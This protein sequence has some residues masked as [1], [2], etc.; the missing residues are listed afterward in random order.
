[1]CNDG[2]LS[3]SFTVP[4]CSP[5]PCECTGPDGAII[6]NGESR[7]YFASATVP[8]PDTCQGE[9]R[10]CDNGV[11]SGS[12]TQ[13]NCSVEPCPPACPPEITLSFV[14]PVDL[15]NVIV[16]GDFEASWTRIAGRAAIG[17]NFTITRF[18]EIAWGLF[19]PELS[20]F[21]A[22]NEVFLFQLI[23]GDSIDWNRGKVFSGSI[24]V[25]NEFPNNGSILSSL[26]NGCEL[27][28][29]ATLLNFGELQTNLFNVSFNLS[30]LDQTVLNVSVD[31]NS[32]LVI[33]LPSEPRAVTFGPD[34]KLAVVVHVDASLLLTA[35]SI[36]VSPDFDQFFNESIVLVFNVQGEACGFN[37]LDMYNLQPWKNRTIWNFPDCTNMT[38]NDTA[39]MGSVLAVNA[40]V[41]DATGLIYGTFIV[42]NFTAGSFFEFEWARFEGCQEL[43]PEFPEICEVICLPPPPNANTTQC[44]C[45]ESYGTTFEQLNPVLDNF[46]LCL[47]DIITR[48]CIDLPSHHERPQ[49]NRCAHD[50]CRAHIPDD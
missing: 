27:I 21:N 12:N 25:G 13:P 41:R 23:V 11:L 26:A 10:T 50:C 40:N 42:N 45:L 9:E 7:T 32:Q 38:I 4:N 36:V 47:A 46:G 14:D 48:V 6:Q 16:F 31:I 18:A 15:F 39:I 8:C 34:G 43:P 20:C 2:N 3:G 24:V 30:L 5:T 28:Q 17:G 1:V 37:K 49:C 35:T 22:G 44:A 33:T 19:R 29:N